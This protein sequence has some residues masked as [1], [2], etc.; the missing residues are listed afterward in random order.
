MIRCGT[1]GNFCCEEH[2]K[3]FELVSCECGCHE[4]SHPSDFNARAGAI[5]RD[6]AMD[7][8]ERAADSEWKRKAWEAFVY[9]AK[10]RKAF[11]T[12]AVWYMLQEW[13]VSAPREPRAMGPM[14]SRA[15]REGICEVTGDMKKSERV[16][17]HRRPIEVYR[18]KIFEERPEADV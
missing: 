9:V 8:V 14:V 12:D 10:R 1:D 17:C 4:V 7:A 13:K 18:S 11:T 3:S 2:G 16:G 5:A 6:A 15:R